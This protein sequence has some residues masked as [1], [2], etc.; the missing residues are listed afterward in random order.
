MCVCVCVGLA[1][2]VLW[3]WFSSIL[4]QFLGCLGILVPGVCA[5]SLLSI[6]LYTRIGVV[7]L[8]PSARVNCISCGYSLPH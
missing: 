3:K 8:S 6:V 5:C 1:R 4:P 2:L 7:L